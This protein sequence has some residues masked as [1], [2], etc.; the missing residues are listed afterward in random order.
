MSWLIDFDSN[1]YA[2]IRAVIFVLSIVYALIYVQSKKREYLFYSLYLAALFLVFLQYVLPEKFQNWYLYL[3][4]PL[5]FLAFFFYILFARDLL[6]TKVNILKWDTVLLFFATVF[7]A[8]IPIFLIIQFFFGITLQDKLFLIVA[9]ILTVFALLSYIVI[10]KIKGKHVR[11][12]IAGSLLF[13]LF[14]NISLLAEIMFNSFSANTYQIQP[15][16]FMHIGAVLETLMVALILGFQLKF[17][18]DKRIKAETLLRLKTE[19]KENLKMTALQSQMDPHFLYNSL[20]SIN[21]FV[22]KNDAEKASDYITKF[23]RLIRE[24]L[25][26]S[27][28][29]TITLEKELGILNLYIKLEQMRISDSFDY[30]LKVDHSLDLDKIEVPP[31]FL[32]PFVENAIWHGLLNKQGKKIIKLHIF[33]E[34]SNIRC[35]LIDNGLGINTTM[36][37]KSYLTEKHKSFGIKATEDRIKLLHKDSKVYLFIEDISNETSTGTKVSLKFPKH[38]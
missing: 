22:L 9:P 21:N 12:F 32:Q 37:E 18:E 5:Q 29:V 20:N 11:F 34:G 4:Y 7:L 24:I 6:K 27:S 10:A 30:I 35:E 19:E 14:A 31:L 2:G 1:F 16:I 13:V 38:R 28:N 36:N 15:M 8:L 23:S 25:N 3:D 33:D 17:Q 26:N